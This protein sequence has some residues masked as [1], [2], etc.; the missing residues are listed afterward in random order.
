MD[1]RLIQS[2]YYTVGGFFLGIMIALTWSF[3]I[4]TH[5]SSL[6]IILITTSISALCGFLF[7]NSVPHWFKAFW[8]FFS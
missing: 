1:A 2:F 3:Y 7:P 6:E 5:T 4:N 8:N